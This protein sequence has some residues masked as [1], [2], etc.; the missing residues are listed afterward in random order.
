MR[1]IKS[2]TFVDDFDPFTAP[3][4]RREREKKNSASSERRGRKDS[5]SRAG[6]GR[7]RQFLSRRDRDLREEICSALV[8]R[9]RAGD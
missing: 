5:A 8:F 4:S 2:S 9:P 1:E 7:K 6:R 3:L